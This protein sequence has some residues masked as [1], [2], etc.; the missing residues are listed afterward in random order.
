M[1]STII[2]IN[3][4]ITIIV[5]NMIVI[6]N[7]YHHNHHNLIDH[8][9]RSSLIITIIDQHHIK[10]SH[11]P[12]LVDICSHI[13]TF[14]YKEYTMFISNC[15]RSCITYLTYYNHGPYSQR[16]TY[17]YVVTCSYRTSWEYIT[18]VNAMD[19]SQKKRGMSAPKTMIRRS[20]VTPMFV[21]FVYHFP[22]HLLFFFSSPSFRLRTLWSCQSSC[23]WSRLRKTK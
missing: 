16:K 19:H 11:S 21:P 2:I 6:I 20:R 9:H 1:L 3:I 5:I 17:K 4:I 22:Q 18:M 8:H 12:R 23:S 13:Q 15:Y 10:Q 14:T 7:N